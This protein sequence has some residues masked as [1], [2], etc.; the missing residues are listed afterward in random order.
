MIEIEINGKVIEC[1]NGERIIS[2]CDREDIPVPRFCY[3]KNLSIA[4]NCRMCLVVVDG[5]PKP[6]PACSTTAYA[7]MK[8]STNNQKVKDSQQAVMEFLLINHPL[9]CPICDQGGECELQDVA[10]NYGSNKTFFSEGKRVMSD[11]DIGPLIQTEMT[12]CIHCTRCVRFGDE[13][14]GLSEMGALGRGENL[15]ITAFL[16]TSIDSELSGNMIDVCPVGALASKPFRYSV[17]SWEMTTHKSIARHDLTGSSLN[18]QTFKHQV[19]R[20]SAGE[21]ESINQSWISDRDR[22]SYTSLNCKNRVLKPKI[23]VEGVWQEVDWKLA[24]EFA[25]KGIKNNLV[26]GNND[27]Q[28]ATLSDSTATLEELY[29]LKKLT[30]SIGSKNCEYRLNISDLS[31]YSYLDSTTKISKIENF[32]EIIIIGGNPRFAEPMLN[33]RIRKAFLSSAKIKVII[34]NDCNFNYDTKKIITKVTYFADEIDKLNLS[35]NSLIV[36]GNEINNS[37]NISKINLA[38]QNSGAKILNISNSGNTIA[39]RKINFTTD[40]IYNKN[41]YILFN[42]AKQDL[43]NKLMKSID[44]ADFV[45][46]LNTFAGM[47]GV[48]DV[49]LPIA[50]LYETSGTH[51]NI[52]EIPQSFEASIKAPNEV[53]P[54]WKVVKVLADM[55]EVKGFEFI[56]SISVRNSALNFDKIIDKV[57][58]QEDIT[59]FEVIEQNTYKT[60]YNSDEFT[61]NSYDLQQTVIAK[62]TT[63][64]G[65][66]V[67]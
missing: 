17:R 26:L 67:E 48:A 42:L 57:T 51:M 54:G 7:G 39:A 41:S 8:L 44:N 38:V 58:E 33:H 34:E 19:Y 43:T 46:A 6:Q 56:D 28:L 65:E 31:T 16:K 45:V 47:E 35:E 11:S 66:N 10:I 27:N 1:E 60:H 15:S 64:G 4:A 20:I 50:G 14:A 52:D 2:V 23:K 36:L 53:K 24:L 55:L 32:K 49:I 13:I 18:I 63:L 25:S 30:N 61:R 37:K 62:N 3:H 5:N 59:D 21:N 9:D 22:F 29:L 40:N 12:R